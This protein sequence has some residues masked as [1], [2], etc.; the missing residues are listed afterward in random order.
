MKKRKK[1]IALLL[2]TFLIFSFVSCS[3]NSG[4][5][6]NKSTVEKFDEFQK[7]IFKEAVSSDL[8][9]LKYNLKDPSKYG[10]KDVKPT[11]GN[12]L[13]DVKEA[14]EGYSEELDKLKEFNI[15]ELTEEQQITYKTLEYYLTLEEGAKDFAY[16]SSYIRKN[17]GVQGQLP[18]LL[19]EYPLTSKEDVEE[20]IELLKSTVDYFNSIG[21]MEKLRSEKGLFISDMEL[22]TVIE[23]LEDFINSPNGNC[24][25]TSFRDRLDKIDSL[26]EE[27]K[28]SLEE[29]NK[30]AVENYVV[31]AYSNLKETLLTLKGT[32]VNEGGVCNFENGK[33]YYEYLVKSL[34]GTDKSV[35]EIEKMINTKAGKYIKELTEIMTEDP[36]IFTSLEN[37]QLESNDPNTI[38]STLKERCKVD[39][40]E[41]DEVSYSINEVVPEL[42]DH[43]NPAFYLTPPIDDINNNVIYVN[44]KSVDDSTMFNTL[45]HEGYPGHLLQTVYFYL[46]NPSEIRTILSNT[47]YVEG[48]A[49][50]VESSC[51]DYA[52][53]DNENIGKIAGI[54]RQYDLALSSLIDIGVNYKGWDLEYLTS[55]LSNFGIDEDTIKNIFI[56]VVRAPGNY[57]SYYVGSLEIEELKEE[58]Q[59]ELE[60]KFDLKEFNKS[61]LDVGPAPFSIVKEGVDNYINKAKGETANKDMDLSKVVSLVAPINIYK[62]VA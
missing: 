58:A 13:E 33:E 59:D 56:Q 38:V 3:K 18:M 49:T 9:T 23:Q 24:L 8:L 57:L 28:T 46:S 41:I 35:D 11:L 19:I 2:S 14:E 6:T 48:W 51:Y 50:Y 36:D 45:A 10:I 52:N 27:D 43:M 26:T 54:S 22:E 29:K 34:V 39:Y 20:Y 25:I 1:L 4:T 61:I 21:E 62:K 40:P 15:D 53:F 55:Y 44:G 5:A 60:D 31:K 37:I 17:G 32:G 30:D 12:A 42:Q 7:D 16:Y 47:G